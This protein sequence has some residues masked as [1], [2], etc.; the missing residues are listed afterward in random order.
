MKEN[1]VRTSLLF[2]F[3][4]SVLPSSAAVPELVI[5]ETALR[6]IDTVELFRN[7][8]YWWT[9]SSCSGDVV[10][11]GGAAYIAYTDPRLLSANTPS[12]AS[13]AGAS[14]G[15]LPGDSFDLG[16]SIQALKVS[17]LRGMLLPDCGYGAHFVR[18]D[19]A[20]Y[21]AKNR[22][23]YRKPLTAS[24]FATGEPISFFVG[25][26]RFPIAADG[27]L[28]A[29]D[30]ELWS[31]A[32]DLAQY[33]LTI[34]RTWKSGARDVRRIREVLTMPGV[35][36]RKFAI[37]DIQATDGS[38]LG[39]ELILLSPNGNLYRAGVMGGSATLVRSGV[40]DFAVR[41]ETYTALGNLGLT[42]KRRATTL[43][44]A[45]D[46]PLTPSSN[47]QLLGLDLNAGARGQFV[48]YPGSANFRV[49]SV[50]V[51]KNHI[52]LT[53][54][55]TSGLANSDLLR[56]NAPAEP[57]IANPGDPDFA[58]IAVTREFRSL[59]STGRLVYFA[60]GNT[61]QRLS[62]N[63][64]VI[65]IDFEAFGIEVTQAIQNMN[66]TVPLVAGRRAYVRGYA[67]IAANST[68]RPGFDVPAH[69]RVYHAPRVPIGQAPFTEVTG[70]P[71]LPTWQPAVSNVVSLQTQRTN[72]SATFQ[73]D[74]PEGVV[75]EGDLRF[76]FLLNPGYSVPETGI[77]PLANNT[78]TATLSAKE[79][80]VLPFTMVPV[81]FNG[82]FYDPNAPGSGFWD[83][84]ARARTLLPFA[85]FRIGLRSPGVSK[86][87]LGSPPRSF[88]LPKEASGALA[89][90]DFARFLDGN[91]LG[92]PYVGMAP[93]TATPFSGIGRRPGQAQVI[94]MTVENGNDSWAPW[95][96]LRGGIS[97]AHEF[98]HNT[99]FRHFR[100]LGC[101]DIPLGSDQTT[102]VTPGNYDGY[103]SG[104]DACTLGLTDLNDPAT[105]T[106]F[107]P[108]SWSVVP[109]GINGELMSYST[110]RWISEYN[111]TR[112]YE[113]HT[114]RSPAF[115]PS[116]ALHTPPPTG[117]FLVLQGLVNLTANSAVLSPAY[118]LPSAELAPAILAELTS[119][120]ENFPANHPV[121][122]QL[123]DNAGVVLAEYL[124]PLESYE[125]GET[126]E[127]SVS[128]AIP[129]LDGA[130]TIRLVNGATVL[131]ELPVSAQ[132]PA[133]ALNP[134]AL[135][136]GQLNLAWTATDADGDTLQ[137]T[138]QLS[139]DDGRTW[140]TLTVNQSERNLSLD[141]TRLPGGAAVRVRTIATDGVR[142]AIATSDA[143]ALPKHAPSVRIT[144]VTDGQQMDFG[145][146]VSA[147]GFGYDAE[148]GS[149]ADAAL[150]WTLDGPDA[151]Q[152]A[153]R[154]LSLSNLSPGAYTLALIG[155]D[156]D[157][158][159]GAHTIQFVI[160]AFTVPDSS[161]E[162]V[163]DG[164]C[165]DHGYANSPPIR[166]AVANGLYANARFTHAN[167]ALFVCF[168][169]LR[170]DTANTSGAVAGL[171][172]DASG[173]G[174]PIATTVGFAVNENGEPLRVAGD[175]SKFVA[176]ENPPPGFSVVILRDENTWSAEMRIEDELLG[177]WS[178]RLGLVAL[179]DDG[180]AATPPET[181]PPH[182]DI[183][184]PS[185]WATSRPAPRPPQELI[186]NGSFENTE[187]TFAGD[188]FGVMSLRVPG[189]STI[190]GWT[191]TSAELVWVDN[192]N[193]FGA[194][195]PFG[196]HSLDLTGY[197][198]GYPYGGVTQTISTTPGQT[199][200]LSL[201]LGS[202]ADYVG[203]G[204][205]KSV[206]VCAG[207][208][209]T[210][211]TLF[212]TNPTGNYWET[213][214]F[215]FTAD[216]LSTVTAI[217]GGRLAGNYLGI[218]NVS[219][220]AE[221][222]TPASA[223]A[224]LVV[225]GN[226][227]TFECPG[228]FAPDGNGLMSLPPGSTAI[229][230]WT[231]T[232]AELVWAMNVNTFGPRTDY[233]SLFLDLTGYHDAP[234]YGGITQT[235]A[236]TPNQSYRLSFSIGSHEGTSS[237]RGP[238]T[239]AV[240]VGSVS[241]AFT[242]IP[243]GFVNQWGT[244]TMD[245]TATGTA[246]P[247]TFTGTASAGGAYLGL[248]NVAVTV[249]TDEEELRIMT[250]EPLGGELRI[251][252]TSVTG[253][254]YLIQRRSDLSSGAWEAMPGT[255][256]LGTGGVIQINLLIDPNQPHQFFRVLQQP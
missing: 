164:L 128:R 174:Q 133:V 137:F 176:L 226:F 9:A 183:D 113:I 105:S 10:N 163:L 254:A 22:G 159:T 109:P 96:S 26:D 214:T 218:D 42:V 119:L 129:M 20:F 39:S 28:F 17:A 139:A 60:H 222:S 198:D 104:A 238:M 50:A 61:V 14:G 87:I 90:V 239:V 250:T 225:N 181:W 177:G 212:P 56:R 155:I 114:F 255:E 185:S 49:T 100:N 152:G 230:A 142:S 213:F 224:D 27:V 134:P 13:R 235:L 63:A 7:G 92:G 37:V 228:G 136:N 81:R 191:T 151:R 189:S 200:R 244:F 40:N 171:R 12:F 110:N 65:N 153:G 112:L 173:S 204:F 149:L 178:T 179:F 160:R 102:K 11:Q 207:S 80:I 199:Y 111:W 77:N 51:D 248:D 79:S 156:S 126:A 162:P 127:A 24:A 138:T 170:Y 46:N 35:S 88:D 97:L 215:Q 123:L 122:F 231:T 216:S 219:V 48:E 157:G 68:G 197:H 135:A 5:Q 93:P 141:S 53:R 107:D 240:T 253:R 203:A 232:G 8:L 188:S 18:D 71:F 95:N 19:E 43:Y 180:N 72:L 246:T 83:I 217:E 167:G 124:A 47:G 209:G 21:F 2:C 45:A 36:L 241:N 195:T 76:E 89:A 64:P 41:N 256:K 201:A 242:F 202:N 131:V 70:S 132:P 158:Q 23:L 115:A 1:A 75:T 211:F 91:P 166:F 243:F 249:A 57:T 101:G 120:P 67:Q 143:F 85:Q 116:L 220:I 52:F 4:I 98:S 32:A 140:Q 236:T 175:G 234:P 145:A 73:F 118:T 210:V 221:N 74:V 251:S 194:S 103:P 130:R 208:A 205:P 69:L 169:G 147:E 86:S 193:T 66:N 237:Y 187:G 34:N 121:R 146:A 30:T 6:T 223:P 245:F 144:G 31:Y 247:L 62:V 196:T 59:R 25:L 106:G 108:I 84:I 33:T 55:P 99:G 184:Q 233:G 172:V 165:A 227:E 186:V 148:D 252:F 94:R 3:L 82:G 150:T 15:F 58:V 190:P 44:M 117:S 16:V 125:D 78:S 54:T 192:T 154:A 38:Y 206:F 29:T 161:V 168:T 182:A 229:A